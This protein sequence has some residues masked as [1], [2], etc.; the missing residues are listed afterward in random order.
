MGRRRHLPVG[1]RLPPMSLLVL[2]AHA[3]RSGWD[4]EV[5]DLSYEPSP[6]DSVDWDGL[7]TRIGKRRRSG[8]PDLA[9]LTVW[10]PNAPNAYRTA[11]AYRRR[12]VP[13]VLGSV[14]ASLLPGEALR[15]ADAV[16]CGEADQIFATVLADAASRRLKP[17]YQGAFQTMD[18]VPLNHEW[19]DLYKTWPIARYA[20]ANTLQT[21]RGCRFN[22]D[23]CSVIRI[24]G[25]GSRHSPVERVIE[26]VRVLK[27]Y[28]QHIGDYTYIF[29]LDDDMA[30]DLDYMAELAEEIL[31]SGVKFTW[32][33]QA[34]IGLARDPKVLDL[35]ARSG[36]HA[37]FTGFESVS[38]EAL[39]ECNKKNR[40]G[41]YGALIGNLHK[42]GIAVEGGFIFGFDHD[43]PDVFEHTA[44]FVDR[45][46]CD[47]AHFSILTPYPGTHTFSRMHD[48]GRITT[49][50]WQRYNLYHVVHQPAQMT[51][52]QLHDGIRKAYRWF[53]GARRRYPRFARHML[54]RDP[55]FNMAFAACNRNY[56][57]RY[58]KL[59]LDDMP[60]FHAD[61]GDVARMALASA[62][63]A[64]DALN[65][66]FAQL[67]SNVALLGRKPTS[68]AT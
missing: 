4:V 68:T 12:G 23:F 64:Q 42:R 29:F 13:V 49:F 31:R 33:Y 58:R 56:D 37:V 55:R 59:E 28:G 1:H 47:V 63:P 21:T 32:G 22:C 20:P 15:H 38:R 2:A 25:R 6:V 57:R 14:H 5:I 60:A 16:V 41:E 30:A 67:S 10:T 66:A 35:V 36:L 62:A 39:I 40:P 3:R 65:V 24:N 53:Y 34:S 26:E 27:K 52:Q 54:D 18:N 8:K 46:D 50:D 48:E 11:D 9:A 51:A 19:V 7:R 45:I 61:S 44:E 17:L 43:K